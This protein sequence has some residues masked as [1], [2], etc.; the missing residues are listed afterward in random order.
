MVAAEWI[1]HEIPGA[2]LEIFEPDEGGSHLLAQEN[3]TRFSAVLRE[4]VVA[5][6]RQLH[7][8][9]TL[10]ATQQLKAKEQ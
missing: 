10:I 1:A 2:R 3:P 5:T 8:K 6:P 7:R 9:F 4:F